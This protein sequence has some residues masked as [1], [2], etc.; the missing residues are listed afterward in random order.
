M[1]NLLE[2]KNIEKSF[3]GIKALDNISFSVP[4]NSIVSIIG[5]NGSGKT[6]FLNCVNGIY[7]PEKG[8]LKFKGQ[9][10]IHKK[11]HEIAKLGISRT[12]QVARMFQKI[13]VIDN[14]LAPVLGS[15]SS[16]GEL[17][18][19]AS[20]LLDRVGMSSLKESLGGDLSGGQQKLIELLRSWIMDSS[21]ILLDEPFAGVHPELKHLFYEEIQ[22]LKQMGK[23]FIL[24]S[25]DMKS[26][27]TLSDEII[28]FDLGAIIAQG[29]EEDIKN[30]DKV[31]EAYLGN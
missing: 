25:H 10:L 13:S 5:P 9:E 23:T 15:K 8:S 30:N 14:I 7:T 19:E 28:V 11:P 16:M 6:T 26:V 22:K 24:I 17:R 31:I 12:F 20:L 3:G 1:N 27:Y 29:N 4:E 21:L 2:A 18:K